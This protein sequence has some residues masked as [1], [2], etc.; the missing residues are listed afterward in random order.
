MSSNSHLL[1]SL[2]AF[3][4]K[5]TGA[6]MSWEVIEFFKKYLNLFLVHNLLQV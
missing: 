6:S 1:D 2:R 4:N 3:Y 5:E